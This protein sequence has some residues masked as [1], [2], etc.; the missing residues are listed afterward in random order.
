MD[1]EPARARMVR[2]FGPGAH[3][4]MAAV[5]GRIAE[6]AE[7]WNLEP[8]E[9]YP[10]GNSSVA[11][12]CGDVVLKLSPQVAFLAEQ[13]RVLRM[14]EPSGRVPRVLQH[15]DGAMVMEVVEPG[16]FVTGVPPAG[17]FAEL[18]ADLH[19]AGDPAI[20]ERDM[21]SYTDELFDRVESHGVDIGSARELRDELVASQTDIVLLHGDLHFG[22][23]LDGPRGLMVIDPKA[24]AGDRAFDAVDYAIAAPDRIGELAKAA[25]LDADR[26]AAWRQVLHWVSSPL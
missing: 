15:E 5:P 13:V 26:L 8:G 6:L 17:E 9:P 18:M 2:R 21:F 11:V 14:Y 19:A 23:I 16:T 24:C 22:N 4:W 25:G 7:R 20:A 12:R 3:A 10:T 1:L